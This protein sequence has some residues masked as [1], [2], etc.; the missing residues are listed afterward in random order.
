MEVGDPATFGSVRSAIEAAYS[1]TRITDFLKAV[2]RA[3]LRIREFE[4]VLKA[5]KLGSTTTADYGKLGNA[6]SVVGIYLEKP[7][8]QLQR[9]LLHQREIQLPSLA[10]V[11]IAQG[12]VSL[13]RSRTQ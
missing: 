3:G 1:A 9:N 2:E 10:A 8:S 4:K 6:S 13:S 7:A 12:A 11:R 5:G